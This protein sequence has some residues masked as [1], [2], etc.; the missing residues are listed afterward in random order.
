MTIRVASIDN[1]MRSI[2][3]STAPGKNV[4]R[5]GSNYAVGLFKDRGEADMLMTSLSESYPTLEMTITE[6][7]I[8]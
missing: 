6:T 5:S 1:K 7:K 3:N 4:M 2:I 8:E